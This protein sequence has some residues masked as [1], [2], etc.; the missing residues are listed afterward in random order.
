MLFSLLLSF[1]VIAQSQT[2]KVSGIVRDEN[3]DPIIGGS[4]TILNTKIVT[5]TDLD[6]KYTLE[7]TQPVAEIQFSYLG[8]ETQTIKVQGD[9]ILDVKLVPSAVALGDDVVIVAYGQQKKVSVTGAIS[10]VSGD[11]L[12]KVPTASIGNMLAGALS[13][14]S[15]VQSSGQPGGDNPDIFV[16][17]IGTLNSANS[18]PLMLVDGIERNIANLDP[19]E[20]ESINVLKDASATAVFGVRGANGVILV[21]TKRGSVSKAQVSASLSYGVQ[22]PTRMVEMVNSYEWVTLHNEARVN[23]GKADQKSFSDATVE[24]FRTGSNPLVYPNVN[25]TDMLFKDF[26]PQSQGNINVSGGTEAIRYFTSVGFL[27]QEGFFKNFGLDYNSNF[28]YKRYNYRAN[29][30]INMTRTSLLTLNVGGVL[31]QR[32]APNVNGDANQLFRQIYWA[33]PLGG[34]GIVDGK[35]ILSNQNLI[36]DYIGKDGLSSYYGRGASLKNNNTL[37]VDL[38]FD[39]KL[40]FI[41]EGLRFN[42]KGSYNTGFEQSK[43]RGTSV[44]SYTPYYMKDMTWLNPDPNDM[45]VVLVR[46]GAAGSSYY[47]E[48]SGMSRNWYAEA[49]L[50]YKRD[51]DKHHVSA[52]A[53]YNQSKRYYP[54]KTAYSEIPTGYVGLVGRATYDYNTTYL[55]EMNVGYNGSENFAPG[56]RYGL[57]PAFSAGWVV[58]QEKFMQSIKFINYLK[59]RASYGIVGNDKFIKNDQQQRFLYLVDAYYAGGGYNFGTGSS[60]YWTNGYYEGRLGNPDLS[61]EKAYKKNIGLDFATL[62]ERLTANVDF[63]HEKRKDILTDPLTYPTY[64][65]IELPVLNLGEVTNK[66]VEVSFKWA[67]QLKEKEFSYFA[68][69]NISYAKNKI[70]YMDEVPSKYQYTMQT[71]HPVGQPFGLR[72]RG[73][74]YDG[75]PDVADHSFVLREG[76]VV[77]EDLNGDGI[78]TDEDKTAI[79]YPNYPLLNGGLTLGFNYKGF[80][81]SALIVGATMTSRYL[82]ETF[83]TPFG[84]KLDG[85]VM[86]TQYENRWTPETRETA[87]LPIMSFDGQ[88]NNYRD[89]ELW[90]KDASYLRLKN[91]QVSYTVKSSALKKWGIRELKP[92]ASAYNLFTLDKL[93]F[94]DPESP[95][96]DRPAYPLMLVMNVGVNINF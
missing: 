52:L 80:D 45:T 79:G 10:S 30:D 50:N 74:Y 21:T 92:F 84:E 41:T 1:P 36:G 31:E 15:T 77:Y 25:W 76:D 64:M 14:V 42:I 51:F 24:A 3:N 96:S 19:N 85:P 46:S 17:G 8:Y 12:T 9:K 56:K 53:L 83:R 62:N 16:R 68:H 70:D 4:I 29:L 22:V 90:L 44:D 63:F 71:G 66:G 69:L 33:T 23:D 58:T 40:D 55:L 57:F 73:F 59:L 6:G 20:I 47:N 87:T 13:G 82:Q 72:V 11:Q 94:I 54:D 49:S 75:M 95:T 89:S 81:F 34:A 35:W 5:V 61:W 93:K 60:S 37:N 65:G 26:S 2:Y 27:N 43:N 67:E 18:A 48:S 78:I 86:K 39:Q 38:A 7:Y 88:K 91:I 32:N 28:D